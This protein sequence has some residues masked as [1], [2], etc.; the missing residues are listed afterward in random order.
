M[1]LQIASVNW[2]KSKKWSAPYTQ[3]NIVLNMLVFKIIAN[4]A[5]IL[6]HIV[7]IAEEDRALFNPK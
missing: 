2:L 7:P 1:N 3:N 6:N 4:K 5:I